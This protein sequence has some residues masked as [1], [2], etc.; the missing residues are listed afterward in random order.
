MDFLGL[1]LQLKK[2]KRVTL[3][4][5]TGPVSVCLV[6]HGDFHRPFHQNKTAQSRMSPVEPRF[7]T[8]AHRKCLIFASQSGQKS[9]TLAKISGHSG[10]EPRNKLRAGATIPVTVPGN[11]PLSE[12]TVRRC[13]EK[14]K[15]SSHLG[16]NCL[17]PAHQRNNSH[18][19]FIPKL[20]YKD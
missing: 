5:L 8:D 20:R 6:R 2:K 11:A 10:Q 19:I 3:K 18:G 16:R 17:M 13:K 4:V 14:K 15:D 7:P 9:L 12:P 1:K